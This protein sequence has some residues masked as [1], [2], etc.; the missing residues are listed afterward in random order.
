MAVVKRTFCLNFSDEV[1]QELQKK[2]HQKNQTLVH[3]L[4]AQ[5]Q[6]MIDNGSLLETCI[7]QE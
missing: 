2:A 5:F 4:E 6:R 7:N 1:L 3:Y